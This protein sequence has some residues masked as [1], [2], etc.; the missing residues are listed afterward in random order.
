MASQACGATEAREGSGTNNSL[1]LPLRHYVYMWP[2]CEALKHYHP[3][4]WADIDILV[5]EYKMIFLLA[6]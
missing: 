1:L 4:T 3:C 5:C 2:V 6:P